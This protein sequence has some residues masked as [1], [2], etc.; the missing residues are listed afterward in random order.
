MDV[1]AYL[2]CFL[3]V[4]QISNVAIQITLMYVVLIVDVSFFGYVVTEGYKQPDC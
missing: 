1:V 2:S 3:Y 4:I